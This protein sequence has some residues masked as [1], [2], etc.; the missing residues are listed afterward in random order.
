[1]IRDTKDDTE[2]GV[3][4]LKDIPIFG[5]FFKT[6]S[7][8][9]ERTEL[10]VLITPRVVRTRQEARTVTNELRQRLRAVI[11]LEQLIE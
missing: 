6:T 10:L 2:I 5:S 11:P 3:P 1:L 8:V 9:T 4:V 7:L